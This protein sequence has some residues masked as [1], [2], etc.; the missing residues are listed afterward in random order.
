[1]YTKKLKRPAS[2]KNPR[3]EKRHKRHF[4]P[5]GQAARLKDAIAKAGEMSQA[6]KKGKIGIEDL[7]TATLLQGIVSGDVISA[8]IITRQRL[9]RENLRLRMRLAAQKLRQS[10]AK[11]RLLNVNAE[12]EERQISH[13]ELV[14]RIRDIY[15]LEIKP[16]QPQLPQ[17]T[18]NTP[19]ERATLPQDEPPAT[20]PGAKGTPEK[21]TQETKTEAGL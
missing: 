4:A 20:G 12:K 8:G 16:Q 7:A 13:G 9:Q 19:E 14:N 18:Q 3:A 21:T 1:M 5:Q 11:E 2:R 10:R 17:S 15:G 6:L